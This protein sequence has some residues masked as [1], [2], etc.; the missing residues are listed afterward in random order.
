MHHSDSGMVHC[1][2]RRSIFLGFTF[3]LQEG[4]KFITNRLRRPYWEMLMKLLRDFFDGQRMH[5]SC[6]AQSF[7][8]PPS[9]HVTAFHGGGAMN[10]Y[11]G[12]NDKKNPE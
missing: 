5:I 11:I 9:N 10:T 4:V 2:T 8:F 7:Q 12:I 6:V 3:S 1:C